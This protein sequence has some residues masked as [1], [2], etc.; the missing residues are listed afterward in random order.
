M[1][2]P[3]RR[4]ARRGAAAPATLLVL[5]FL[6]LAVVGCSDQGDDPGA[7]ADGSVP[8]GVDGPAADLL[9]DAS[10]VD[11]P[12]PIVVGEDPVAFTQT[13][14]TVRSGEGDEVDGCFLVADTGDERARGLMGVT[15]LGGYDGMLFVFEEEVDGAF[16]MKDTP[17][18]L[19]IAWFDSDGVLVSSTDMDPCVD[20]RAEADECPS[21]PAGGAFRFAIEVPQGQLE[22]IGVDG[23]DA[24]LVV[25]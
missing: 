24:V 17:A 16:T 25:G 6:L 19:S 5:P 21:Y 10:C 15:D 3:P 22:D 11:Q 1:T 13:R 9:T 8:T 7:A 14:L 20:E 18:P 2:V 12:E 23:D 4:G